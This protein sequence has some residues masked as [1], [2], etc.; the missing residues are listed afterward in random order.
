MDQKEALVDQERDNIV[1]VEAVVLVPV[2]IHD[3]G[4][5]FDRRKLAKI[6]RSLGDIQTDLWAVVLLSESYCQIGDKTSKK[7]KYFPDE[8]NHFETSVVVFVD[9]ASIVVDAGKQQSSYL[10][11]TRW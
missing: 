3:A 11:E 6:A 5:G 4:G 2:E 7:G 10:L 8:R 1:P 9:I